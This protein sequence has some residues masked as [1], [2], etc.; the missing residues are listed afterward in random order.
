MVRTAMPNFQ[1]VLSEEVNG[2]FPIRLSAAVTEG[3]KPSVGT[4]IN[5]YCNAELLGSASTRGDGRAVFDKTLP[6]GVYSFE[7]AVAEEPIVVSQPEKRTF[8]RSTPKT[9]PVQMPADVD[10]AALGGNGSYLIA[11]SVLDKDGKGCN[12][13]RIYVVRKSDGAVI[14]SSGVATNDDKRG[15]SFVETDT[16]GRATISFSFT[17]KEVEL[18]VNVMGLVNQKNPVALHL[19]GPEPRKIR[20]PRLEIKPGEEPRSILEAIQLGLKRGE[21]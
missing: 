4:L 5:F 18:A 13:T 11:I 21:G 12:K 6:E 7:A 9:P 3:N 15:E 19:L 17:E 8:K 1:V 16:S 2:E 20:P 10:V 14:N